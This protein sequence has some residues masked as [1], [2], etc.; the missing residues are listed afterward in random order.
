MESD[1][2]TPFDH[3]SSPLRPLVAAR[4]SGTI[5]ILIS[6]ALFGVHYLS[7]APHGE[8]LDN[9]VAGGRA[10]LPHLTRLV[11]EHQNTIAGLGAMTGLGGLAYIWAVGRDTARVIGVFTAAVSLL[12]LGAL[13]IN[14]AMSQPVHTVF[15]RFR[16]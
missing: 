14:V 2:F 8:L 15:T 9:T 1:T 5:L 4:L 3:Q 10:A 6:G 16:H 7:I 12:L 13:A 11:L